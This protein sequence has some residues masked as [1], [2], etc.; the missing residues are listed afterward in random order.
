MAD[1]EATALNEAMLNEAIDACR[2]GSDDA[3]SPELQMLAQAIASDPSTRRRY[4]QCQQ[5]DAAIGRAIREP[6]DPPAGLAERL[7]AAVS[8]ENGETSA[9][10]TATEP[11]PNPVADVAPAE[12]SSAPNSASAGNTSAGNTRRQ[13]FTAAAALAVVAACVATFFWWPNGQLST[14]QFANLVK[15]WDDHVS[16]Q[17]WP[18]NAADQRFREHFSD[19]VVQGEFRRWTVFTTRYS[20][21]TAAY[22]LSQMG[23]RAKLFC[24]PTNMATPEIPTK[25]PGSLLSSTGGL[26]IGAWKSGGLVYVLVVEGSVDD[27]N[28]FIEYQIG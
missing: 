22:E 16:D 2:P 14:E 11:L 20:K 4:E 24:F 7:L 6:I 9:L 13:I 19:I 25:F 28:S 8:A 5:L 27:Y 1:H 12:K 21:T 18:W 17:N 26:C 10:Q 15:Q 23:V 3:Q